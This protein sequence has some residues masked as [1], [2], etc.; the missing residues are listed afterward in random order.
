MQQFLTHQSGHTNFSNF[1]YQA[2]PLALELCSVSTSRMTNAI[3]WPIHMYAAWPHCLALVGNWLLQHIPVFF[4]PQQHQRQQCLGLHVIASVH[5]AIL[6]R[7]CALRRQPTFLMA[8]CLSNDALS[9]QQHL[10]LV[11]AVSISDCSRDKLPERSLIAH[12]CADIPDQNTACH[13]SCPARACYHRHACSRRLLL[14]QSGPRPALQK[15][16]QGPQR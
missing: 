4:G 3:V 16:Q 7:Q 1:C 2:Q 8:G 12:A 9:T 15:L 14:H 5:Q 13:A 11:S 6:A 10:K